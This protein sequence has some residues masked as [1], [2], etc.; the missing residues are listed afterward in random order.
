VS[1]HIISVYFSGC[2]QYP[3]E[4]IR[5]VQGELSDVIRF[6]EAVE[7]GI[8]EKGCFSAH[9]AF[10]VFFHEDRNSVVTISITS[11]LCGKEMGSSF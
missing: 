4:H 1:I 11:L 3:S 2:D 9:V 7:K 6:S 8:L 10:R 5:S